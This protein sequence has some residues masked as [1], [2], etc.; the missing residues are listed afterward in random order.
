MDTKCKTC[1]INLF[2][3]AVLNREFV[4]NDKAEL[5]AHEKYGWVTQRIGH[6]PQCGNITTE[7]M[8]CHINDMPP[9]PYEPLQPLPPL[10]RGTHP[11]T[12][13][14]QATAK[15]ITGNGTVSVL[16]N[17]TT[18]G[19]VTINDNVTTGNTTTGNTTP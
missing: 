8:D 13:R 12:D 6:C 2:V 17:A 3:S 11:G 4:Q 18:A 19:N 10:P 15:V 16:G 1:G 14:I 5:V 7:D 9:H